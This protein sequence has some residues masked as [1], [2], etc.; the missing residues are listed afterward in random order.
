MKILTNEEF[1]EFH[2]IIVNCHCKIRNIL[3]PIEFILRSPCSSNFWRASNGYIWDEADLR[4]GTV[5]EMDN[6]MRKKRNKHKKSIG[7]KQN[8]KNGEWLI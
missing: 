2:S 7:L 1:S 4:A 8:T 6:N 5:Y 3:V